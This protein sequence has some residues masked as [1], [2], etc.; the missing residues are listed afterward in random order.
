MQ[1]LSLGFEV[2][3]SLGFWCWINTHGFCCNKVVSTSSSNSRFIKK[4]KS[5]AAV[6]NEPNVQKARAATGSSTSW[7]HP[8]HPPARGT[9]TTS[10]A[11]AGSSRGTTAPLG[12]AMSLMSRWRKP[13]Q[14][15]VPAQA[16]HIRQQEEQ[17]QQLLH[18]QGQQVRWDEQQAVCSGWEDQLSRTH[19][20]Q[21][22]QQQQRVHHAEEQLHWG[23]PWVECPGW[24]ARHSHTHQDN[25]WA[26][27]S[28]SIN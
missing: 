20:Q 14:P 19:Q 26:P 18:Q 15:E 28:A 22:E 8:A 10:R 6:S 16:G 27:T 25:R 4:D 12:L 5:S 23:Q 3:L 24:G 11:A 7:A 21:Q 1:C 13:E 2:Q 17:Q 9:A